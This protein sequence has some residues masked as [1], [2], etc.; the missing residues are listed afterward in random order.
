MI[1]ALTMLPDKCPQP[2]AADNG[3]NAGHL[4]KRIRAQTVRVCGTGRIAENYGLQIG[5]GTHE[6]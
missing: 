3:P 2:G 4:F 1:D 5:R 6:F